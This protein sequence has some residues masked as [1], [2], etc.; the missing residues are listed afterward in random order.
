MCF[1]MYLTKAIGDYVLTWHNTSEVVKAECKYCSI[2]VYNCFVYVYE[3][4]VTRQNVL[5]LQKRR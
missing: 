2:A 5:V 1:I 3:I 4:C